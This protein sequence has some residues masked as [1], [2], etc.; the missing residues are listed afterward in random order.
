M[1][2]IALKQLGLRRVSLGAV[3]L[4]SFAHQGLG[5][6][7]QAGRLYVNDLL[8][9]EGLKDLRKIQDA[10]QSAFAKVK[11]ATVGI[12]LGDGSGSGVIVSE[13][14]LVLTAAHV[15]IGVD[16][17]ITVILEDGTELPAKTLG[18]N[19][20]T[21]SG[22]ARIEN[23]EGRVFPYVEL[24]REDSTRLGDW[25][26]A[27]GHSGGVDQS[28]GV[29][30]RLGRL[31]RMTPNTFQSD[32]KLIGGDSGGP[33]FDLNG[34]LIGI[35]SRVALSLEQNMH[36][37]LRD[38]TEN[39]DALLAGEFIGEGPFA[40]KPE[41]ETAFLGVATEDFDGDGV[42]VTRVGEDS[43]AEKAKLEVGDVILAIGETEIA[44]KESFLKLLAEAVPGERM[45]LKVLRNEETLQVEVELDKRS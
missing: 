26:V 39:W 6:S 30:V 19:A 22:M 32:C 2:K 18:L 7:D 15:A 35:H 29:V 25:V 12:K 10:A 31:I 37:P 5:E 45:V 41:L 40:Q 17:D 13:D 4:F 21:D 14:G 28:R 20:E 9:P 33:L 3:L 23:T 43:P 24:D 34:M 38:F 44:D 11:A 42:K 27:L 8:A 16:K 1:L 36:V